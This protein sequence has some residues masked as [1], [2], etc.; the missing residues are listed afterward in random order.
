MHADNNLFIMLIMREIDSSRHH[1]SVL[2]CGTLNAIKFIWE[3]EMHVGE[4]FFQFNYQYIL[5]LSLNLHFLITRS[6][7]H[8][9]QNQQI[10]RG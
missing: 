5:K 2:L 10:T 1:V 6:G 3:V 7:A 8:L 4:N 9:M